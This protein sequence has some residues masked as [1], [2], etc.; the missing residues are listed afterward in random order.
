MTQIAEVPSLITNF[1][2]NYLKSI[3]ILGSY[4]NDF[5]KNR[6]SKIIFS[7][8]IERF[9]IENGAKKNAIYHNIGLRVLI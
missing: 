2:V 7:R 1:Y 3:S 5:E 9:P 4:K 6:D 8:I